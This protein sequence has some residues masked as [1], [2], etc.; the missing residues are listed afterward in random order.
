[1]PLNYRGNYTTFEVCLAW[2]EKGQRAMPLTED[3]AMIDLSKLA[4][5]LDVAG[6]GSLTRA[7]QLSGT[8]PPVLSRR[9]SALE[10]EIGGALFVRTG[11]G[12]GA[13]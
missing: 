13:V 2:S 4:M 6:A 1:M 11:R 8:A 10:D 12:A 9:L 5:F 7:A 3:I